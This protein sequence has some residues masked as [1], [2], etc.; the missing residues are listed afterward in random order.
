MKMLDENRYVG[1]IRQYAGNTAPEGWALCDGQLLSV[2]EHEV[3]FNLIGTRFGGDGTTHFAVPDLRSRVALHASNSYPLSAKGGQEEVTL[4][5]AQL[6]AHGHVAYVS[7]NPAFNTV[8]PENAF[9]GRNADNTW[10]PG[11][12]DMPMH[13]DTIR[14]AGGGQP[15]ENRMPFLAIS[16]IISLEGFYPGEEKLDNPYVILS[17]IR[18][19][20]YDFA[21]GGWAFCNGQRLRIN[22]NQA[23]YSVIRNFYGGD[24]VDNFQLP[25]LR[26][27]VLVGS[28]RDYPVASH[29]GEAAHVLTVRELAP[30]KHLVVGSTKPSDNPSPKHNFWPRDKPYRTDQNAKLHEAA[31]GTTGQNAPHDNMSPFLSLNYCIA[32]QG[33]Y[34][35]D[36]LP[37]NPGEIGTIRANPILKAFRDTWLVC[38]G[39][40]LDKNAYYNLFQII[41]Y[42]YGGSGDK[43]KL[44]DL[45]GRI[46]LGQGKGEGLSRYLVGQAGGAAQV[47]LTESQLPAHSHVPAGKREGTT[48]RPD[49]MVWAGKPDATD[50]FASEAGTAPLMNAGVLAVAGE[51]A[52]HNNMMPYVSM[53]FLIAAKE[54]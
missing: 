24:G 1:E 44:P 6:P 46:M 49:D 48:S 2:K 25:D 50:G 45:R 33:I 40:S 52:P 18:I 42:T 31:I 53:L 11:P 26:G 21:P 15:H 12:G 14:Q 10:S 32:M 54:S 22:V 29:G 47:S 5:E 41:G 30:H 4:T 28:T 34:P 19:F 7:N 39:Q 20:P 51:G 36:R 9:W 23:I 16:Y 8:G 27:R 35:G 17:E 3:L 38:E 37:V 43:F 13:P